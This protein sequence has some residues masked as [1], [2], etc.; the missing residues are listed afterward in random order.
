MGFA[1]AKYIGLELAPPEIALMKRLK[2]A[3]DP[4]GI[5]NPGKIFSDV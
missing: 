2:Q 3:F 4:R 5:L 1:K